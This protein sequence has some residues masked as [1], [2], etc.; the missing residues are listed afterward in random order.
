[1]ITQEDSL[2][3]THEQCQVLLQIARAALEAHLGKRPFTPPPPEDTDLWQQAGVF[4]TLWLQNETKPPPYWPQGHLRGCVGHIHSDLPL[5]QA[6]AETAVDAATNDP[7]FPSLTKAELN[8]INLEI[9]LLSP[10]KPVQQLEEIEI[11]KH[12]LLITQGMQRGLL[13]PQVAAN[14]KWDRKQFLTAVCAKANLPDTI[15]PQ[16]ARLY[17]FTTLE[18]AE[19]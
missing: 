4:V 14:R 16:T 5:Y 18:F 19:Q 11:G 17:A 7:R 9:S 8:H 3:L 15:W 2:S 1:M 13:L 12:G 6:V 10:M